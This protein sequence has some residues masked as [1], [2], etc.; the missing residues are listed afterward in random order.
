MTSEEAEIALVDACRTL[1]KRDC[2]VACISRDGDEQFVNLEPVRLV[3]KSRKPTK[4][5]LAITVPLAILSEDE[6]CRARKF[7]SRN[8]VGGP[9]S[10][11]CTYDGKNQHMIKEW[12]LNM[13]TPEES[14]KAAIGAF[15]AIFRP[16]SYPEYEVECFEAEIL[17]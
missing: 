14:A 16:P 12:A 10:R 3:S 8:G 4:R 9:V 5:L 15:E 11:P 7:F 2:H 6:D 1:L 13:E 17:E